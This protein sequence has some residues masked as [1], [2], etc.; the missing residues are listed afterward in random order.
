MQLEP[1]VAK[2]VPDMPVST[3]IVRFW[4][5]RSAS[6]TAWRGRI[7]HSQSGEGASFLQLRDMLAF[8]HRLGI[9]PEGGAEAGSG[10]SQ[11]G[12]SES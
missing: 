8:M 12:G 4:H 1:K 2:S 11:S 5:E 7:T 9:S 6:G 10:D 3:F